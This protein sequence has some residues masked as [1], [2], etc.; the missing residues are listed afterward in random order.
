MKSSKNIFRIL[1]LIIFLSAVAFIAYTTSKDDLSSEDSSASVNLCGNGV[2]DTGE[3]CDGELLSSSCI[4]G[5]DKCSSDCKGCVHSSG[6][7]CGNGIVEKGEECDP[8]SKLTGMCGAGTDPSLNAVGTCTNNCICNYPSDK[9]N[10][11]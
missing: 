11:N 9:E 4:G 1:I 3:L 2:L 10:T 7:T 6:N 5:L 8:N